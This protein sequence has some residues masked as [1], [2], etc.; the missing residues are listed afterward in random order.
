MRYVYW[1]DDCFE[2]MSFV[3]QGVVTKLWKLDDQTADGIASRILIFGNAYEEADRDDLPTQEDEDKEERD[4]FDKFLEKCARVDGP[5]WEKPLYNAK[6][7]LVQKVVKYLYKQENPADRD[8]YRELKRSWISGD[9]TN[10][11]GA[12]YQEAAAAVAGLIERMDLEPESVVGIDLMLLHDDIGRLLKKKRIISMELCHN[13]SSGGIP[14]FLY[15]S[16]GGNDDVV[17]CWQKAYQDLYHETGIKIYKRM[18]F[19][20]KGK[21]DIIREIEAMFV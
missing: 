11:A 14:C 15:S 4:V 7:G 1:I 20:Q 16:E 6:K 10:P 9:L 12:G 19:M 3:M 17:R 21:I 13:L 8:A 5:D 18:D 2:Q